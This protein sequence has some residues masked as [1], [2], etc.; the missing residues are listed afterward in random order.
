MR[1]GP[2]RGSVLGRGPFGAHNRNGSSYAVSSLT[3]IREGHEADLK[4]HLRG[5]EVSPF[6]ELD[7]VHFARWLVIDQFNLD[8]PG[9]P[10]HRTQLRS[11]YLLFA[12]SVTAG[13]GGS[14]SKLP[15]SFLRQIAEQVPDAADAVWGHCVGYPGTTSPDDFASYLYRSL[16]DTVLFH[17]GYRNATVHG[18]RTALARRDALVRFVREHQGESDPALLQQRYLSESA[19]WNL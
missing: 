4:A 17:A 13:D 8:W 5:L 6:V 19:T 1:P 14:A 11:R 2:V 12:A 7:S 16:L 18:V 3:P 10:A 9:A 15:M